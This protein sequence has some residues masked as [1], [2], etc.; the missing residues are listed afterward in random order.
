M[1]MHSIPGLGMDSNVFVVENGGETVV[2]DAGMDARAEYVLDS[3]GKILRGAKPSALVLT[4][5]HIDHVGGAAAIVR[6]YGCEAVMHE[7]DADAIIKGDQMSTGAAMF[8]GVAEPMRVR[9]LAEGEMVAGMMVIHT[10]G[11]TIGSM[12]LYDKKSKALISGD[13]VFRDGVGR[14]DL[15]T[16]DVKALHESVAM[17][18]AMEVDGIYPGHGEVAETG[19]SRLIANN[20]RY[21]ESFG[22]F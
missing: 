4:H 16:G 2:I 8:G 9:K 5:M 6:K 18:A 17:L 11:H 22:G 1:K 21:L 13:T 10:P 19:G 12:C 3:L 20:L 15:P 14:W 7:K